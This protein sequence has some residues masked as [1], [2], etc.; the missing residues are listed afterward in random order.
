[1]EGTVH[2]TH[3]LDGAAER[4]VHEERDGDWCEIQGMFVVPDRNNCDLDMQRERI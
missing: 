1:M 4:E 3:P 2:F